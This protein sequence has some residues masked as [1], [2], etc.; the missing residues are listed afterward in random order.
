MVIHVKDV[1]A[2]WLVREFARRRGV[3]LTEAIKVAIQEATAHETSAGEALAQRIEPLLTVIRSLKPA[4]GSEEFD[5][6]F[7]DEMWGED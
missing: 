4:G 2:D 6:P 1:E 3:G 7:M 5:K